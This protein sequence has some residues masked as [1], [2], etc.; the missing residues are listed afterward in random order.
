MVMADLDDLPA[1]ERFLATEA[2]IAATFGCVEE[3]VAPR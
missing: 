1:A 3:A 2:R